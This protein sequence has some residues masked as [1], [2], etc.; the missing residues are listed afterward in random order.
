MGAQGSCLCRQRW[1]PLC[2]ALPVTRGF[3][4]LSGAQEFEI[5]LEGSQTLR[6]LCYEKCYHKT[7]LT[8]EDGGENADRI[9][10]KGQAQ[11]RRPLR[12]PWAPGDP[13]A[14]DPRPPPPGAPCASSLDARGHRG[15]G[16]GTQ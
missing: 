10:G 16:R 4:P 6:I 3:P 9:V 5:E 12:C 15:G 1:P 11:V 14:S 13:P 8:K 2:R 7:R